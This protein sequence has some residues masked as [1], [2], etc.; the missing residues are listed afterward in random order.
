MSTSVTVKPSLNPLLP[1]RTHYSSDL[2]ALSVG[3]EVRLAGWAHRCRDHGGLIFIDLRD[4]RGLVQL[5]ITPDAPGDSHDIAA[6]VRPEWVLQVVGVI[7]PRPEGT[8]NPSLATGKIEIEVS[9]IEILNVAADMP[10]DVA[11][12]TPITE[13]QNIEFR[14][15][16]LRRE[17]V[18]KV[19]RF[20]HELVR[21]VREYFYENNF[22]EV[23]TPLLSKSTPEGARDC[24]VPSR[25]FPG[26]FYALPQ[27][28]QQYKQLL[29]IGGVERYFQIARC[30]RDE[31]TRAD[32]LLE[33]TQIDFEMSYVQRDDIMN[34]LEGLIIRLVTKLTPEKRLLSNPLQ[35]FTYREL[36]DRFGSDKPD[37]RFGLEIR[38]CTD[39]FSEIE[40]QVFRSVIEKG[41]TIRGFWCPA[42]PSFSRKEMDEL[43]GVAMELG[44][45]G[46]VWISCGAED[47]SSPIK[48]FLSPD[49]LARLR[50]R[51][52]AAPGEG[53]LFLMAGQVHDTVLDRLGRF[54]VKISER[55]NLQ[56][57][58]LLAFAYVI[59]FPYF[60]WDED[61]KR[62]D[63][64]HHMFVMP[65]REYINT[66]LTDPLPT[67][68]TQFDM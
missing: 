5:R 17:S 40:F 29:V 23:E 7:K 32:R 64:C 54:R 50:D 8:E 9:R 57:P 4:P 27:S 16:A 42:P 44:A 59:D 65:K 19:V 39:L 14:Y 67:L 22:L 30:L 61:N 68:S 18:A 25:V 49:L 55:A 37:L 48:R 47:F 60:F 66:V 20:R 33:H 2:A 13:Q 6:K 1:Y 11:D 53:S 41:G 28:P 58:N 35:R 46:L 62:Y 43:T 26:K 45:E 63:P 56:D 36:M 24:L 10:F 52:E 3:A 38:D 21:M 34:M 31:D 12:E 51:V 15:I